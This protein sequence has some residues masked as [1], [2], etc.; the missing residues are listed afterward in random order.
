MVSYEKMKG[1]REDGAGTG[2]DAGG[3]GR[4]RND[5]NPRIKR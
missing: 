3:L 1:G 5:S 4:D 2:T